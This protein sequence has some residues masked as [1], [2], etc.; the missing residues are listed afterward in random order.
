MHFSRKF[1]SFSCLTKRFLKLTQNPAEQLKIKNEIE[2]PSVKFCSYEPSIDF[3]SHNINVPSNTA[4]HLPS[5]LNQYNVNAQN[6]FCWSSNKSD[7]WSIMYLFTDTAN[8]CL[9]QSTELWKTIYA[10]Q[11]ELLTWLAANE[12]WTL[13]QFCCNFLSHPISGTCDSMMAM[14]SLLSWLHSDA[15]SGIK[16]RKWK[17]M[18]VNE[19]RKSSR[20]R[21]GKA[22]I[23]ITHVERC[24]AHAE[25]V[26]SANQQAGL[27]IIMQ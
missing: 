1:W 12:A 23:K 13:R 15:N 3:H 11:L 8:R 24:H 21:D 22:S 18:L 9:N 7:V 26:H 5:R 27:H 25:G 19:Q 20:P 2:R 17:A 4:D 10:S 16:Q 6:T 14:F